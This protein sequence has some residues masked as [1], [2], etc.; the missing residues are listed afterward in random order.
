[1]KKAKKTTV[2]QKSQQDWNKF[3]EEKSMK[4][5]LDSHT[6]SQN[7]YLD[8]QEFMA[9]ADYNKFLKEKESRELAR[10]PL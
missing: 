1:M 8:K 4:E 9:K 2:L 6:R 3:V 10:K 7:S 5:E